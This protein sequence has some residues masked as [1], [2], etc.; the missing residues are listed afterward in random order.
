MK[1]TSCRK[2]IT[3][4]VNRSTASA[5]VWAHSSVP[6][7]ATTPTS[8]V[9]QV[10]VEF[11]GLIRSFSRCLPV[12]DAGPRPWFQS[13]PY[14]DRINRYQAGFMDVIHSDFHPIFSLGLTIP[15]GDI[16]FF[17]NH[18]TIQTGC[19]R[20]KWYQGWSELRDE[21]PLVSAFQFP[22]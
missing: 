7:P 21:G 18:G 20:D 2:L 6:L 11:W 14:Y 17:P 4:L 16:D 19:M 12:L 13:K 9:S 10:S 8:V 5:T 3:F 1:S 22:R 15:V